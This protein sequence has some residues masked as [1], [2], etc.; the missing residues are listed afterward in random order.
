VLFR[1]AWLAL[2]V[3]PAVFALSFLAA[4]VT[5]AFSQNVLTYHNNNSRTGLNPSEA[6]LTL[7]N[8][9]AASFGKLFTL[10]ADGRVDGEP[11]YLS[12]V[13]IPGNGTHNLLI[14]VTEND[15]VYAFDADSGAVIW[16]VTTLKS[17]ETPSD[18]RGC[19]QV[20]P[21]IG[22]TSTP[23]IRRPTGSNGVI[24]TVAMS[25]DSAG[26]YHQRLHALDATTGDELYKGPADITAKYPGDGDNSSGGYVVFD[27]AQYEERAGLL[28]VGNIIYLAWT[29][30]CD[31]RPYTGWIMGY[32]ATTL[33]QTTVL[34]VTPNGN[35]GAIWGSG[36]GL[37]ADDSSNIFFLDANGTFDTTLNSAGFPSSGD[38]GNAFLR[39]ATKSGL[40]VAD[41]FE[42]DNGVSESDSDTD[43]GSGGAL[44][45]PAMKDSS[46]T[47]WELAV[48]AG[49]DTNLYVV[50]RN[51][52]GKFSAG[53]NN[54]YQE[55][56][57]ALPGG[58]WSMPAFWSG[59]LYFG[60]VSQPILEFQFKQAKL[61]T[62]AVAKTTNTFVYPGAT[63][64]ISCNKGSN[65]IVWAVANTNPA[66]LYAYNATT[67]AELYNSNQAAGG[68]DN[69][70][71]GNKFI[72]PMIANGKVYVGTTTGVGVFGLL[73][74]K[75]EAKER[76]PAKTRAA[77]SESAAGTMTSSASNREAIP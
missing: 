1:R 66:V 55:L 19:G 30:H 41:Y 23:V 47:T 2:L 39:L 25:K 68:R 46:G 60:P 33:A 48:G 35:E 42:M 65:A 75:A 73:S 61:A 15:S 50:N 51:S 40:A 70:G 76:T 9:N 27:P 49:K 71:A 7:G 59:R 69:F 31:I 6:T 52:M 21:Q 10:T 74:D 29:S 32:N 3:S 22:I 44:L 54:I 18:D 14:V 67:L 77:S 24:Y 64:S 37:T 20:T 43:L 11:L 8:V 45:L 26:N 34:N 4:T 36:S 72:T 62:T 57:G 53:S 38:Y 12:A 28:Q 16:H 5:S 13:P 63:P 56:A 58:I 17:G